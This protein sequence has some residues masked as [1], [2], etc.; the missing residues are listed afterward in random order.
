MKSNIRIVRRDIRDRTEHD[1]EKPTVIV[2]NRI[3]DIL[4]NGDH[5]LIG[6]ILGYLNEHYTVE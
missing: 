4:L 2:N 1:E 5:V 3:V 6:E